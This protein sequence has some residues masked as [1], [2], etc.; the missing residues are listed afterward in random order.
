VAAVGGPSHRA[1]RPF[2][3]SGTR[4][5]RRSGFVAMGVNGHLQTNI[6]TMSSYYLTITAGLLLLTLVLFRATLFRLRGSIAQLPGP[7]PGSWLV[8]KSPRSR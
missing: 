5:V 1:R 2:G 7:L 8:G 4:E 3:L 6:L